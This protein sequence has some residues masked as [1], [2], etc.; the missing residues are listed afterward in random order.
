MHAAEVVQPTEPAGHATRIRLRVLRDRGG[1]GRIGR[2]DGGVE[3]SNSFTAAARLDA[4]M[5]I[6]RPGDSRVL[7]FLLTILDN[8]N[9]P[10]EARRCDSSHSNAPSQPEKAWTFCGS[11]RQRTLGRSA[12]VALQVLPPLT[13]LVM[14][15]KEFTQ[16]GAVWWILAPF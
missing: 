2:I 7:P 6:E 5:D 8:Q 16:M 1:C 10:G 14:S 12:P 4:H 11:Y 3:G 15:D 9:E 13:L